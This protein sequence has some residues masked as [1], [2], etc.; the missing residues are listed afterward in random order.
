MRA[1]P[2]DETNEAVAVPHS[3][4]PTR[5]HWLELMSEYRQPLGLAVT[6]L[7]FTIALIA[8]RH[9]LSELDL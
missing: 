9:L 6:L 4:A 1:N 5:L 7:L 3:I 8:C 2:P